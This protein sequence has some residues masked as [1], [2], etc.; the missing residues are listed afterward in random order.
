MVKQQKVGY[1]DL[2]QSVYSCELELVKE[3]SDDSVKSAMAEAL[4]NAYVITVSR[5]SDTVHNSGAE[6]LV[7]MFPEQSHQFLAK[8]YGCVENTNHLAR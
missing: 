1:G 2:H 7:D 5:D 3:C 4:I 8:A 6:Q